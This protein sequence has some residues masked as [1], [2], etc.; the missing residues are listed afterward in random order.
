MMDPLPNVKQDKIK[1]VEINEYITCKL[2]QGYF[3]DATTISE[4]LHSFCRSCIIQFLQENSH[5]PVCE[6]IINKAKPNIKLDKTLQDIVYKLVPELFINEMARRQW[7]YMSRPEEKAKTT[8]EERGVDTERTIFNLRDAI[9]LSIEYISDDSTP[10]AINVPETKYNPSQPQESQMKRFLKCPGNCRIE[11]L[12]KFVQNKYSVDVGSFHIEI[13]YKRVPLPNHYTLID[14][15]YI[16]SWKRNEPMKFFFR[17]LDKV[18]IE[19]ATN[20]I[21]SE[22]IFVKPPKSRKKLGI[23]NESDQNDANRVRNGKNVSESTNNDRKNDENFYQKMCK[24]SLTLIKLPQ[25]TNDDKN[26]E[27]NLICFDDISKIV[28]TTLKIGEDALKFDKNSIKT[29]SVKVKKEKDK[30]KSQKFKNFEVEEN[31]FV[32]TIKNEENKLIFDQIDDVESLKLVKNDKKKEINVKIEHDSKIIKETKEI[33]LDELKAKVKNEVEEENKDHNEIKLNQS[34]LKFDLGES[35]LIQDESKLIQGELKSIQSELKVDQNELKIQSESK[36]DQGELK[37]V[38]DELK[39]IQNES[40]VDQNESKVDQSV[41]EKIPSEAEMI[42]NETEMIKNQSD[43]KGTQNESKGDEKVSK[44]FQKESKLLQSESKMCQNESKV[45]QN[46]SKV[47]QNESKLIEDVSK[48]CQNDSKLIK[49][50]KDEIKMSQ[51]DVKNKLKIE[52]EVKMESNDV[53]IDHYDFEIEEMREKNDLGCYKSKKSKIDEKCEFFKSIELKQIVDLVKKIDEKML[54]SEE[55]CQSGLKPVQKRKNPSPLKNEAGLSLKRVKRKTPPQKIVLNSPKKANDDLKEIF[56]HCKFNIPSSLSITLKETSLEDE[57]RNLKLE[58]VKN[59]IE[60]LK[61]P[62]QKEK[63]ELKSKSAPNLCSK[64][65]FQ[66]TPIKRASTDLVNPFSKK[67]RF[68]FEKFQNSTNLI[69]FEQNVAKLHSPSLNLNYTVSVNQNVMRH[70]GKLDPKFESFKHKKEKKIKNESNEIVVK[71][72]KN[73]IVQI[74]R[75]KIELVKK[76]SKSP[77][78]PP[79]SIK[80]PQQMVPI[81][82]KPSILDQ[83][84]VTN[85]TTNQLMEKYNIQNLAQLTASLHFNPMLNVNPSPVVLQ[86]AILKQFEMQNRQN[87]QLGQFQTNN[88]YLSAT[89]LNTNRIVTK[90]N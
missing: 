60:I 34:E 15:A 53:K 49:M 76:N 61:I 42:Q 65:I 68:D 22:H 77:S 43:Q 72:E 88:K 37:V 23:L 41:A 58:P 16:Y 87:W 12:K 27:Q 5:C 62:D 17:I 4:C 29:N 75:H 24:K 26:K 45:I 7:F 52:S 55:E 56:S 73:E 64:P 67:G 71:E 32:K 83:N 20:C 82:P 38:Q 80:K 10:G 9:S 1:L 39:L 31:F 70:F 13:L 46:E 36:I 66:S 14:I 69:K 40:K 85:L 18:L 35:K 81:L 25:N 51:N 33:N 54:K 59:F 57:G 79:Q 47:I 48:M 89:N 28:E 86:Q 78:S 3:I 19:K 11:I 8:P 74:S 6:M 84:L 90:E 2:C 30:V 50:D 44:V 63:N 21:Y